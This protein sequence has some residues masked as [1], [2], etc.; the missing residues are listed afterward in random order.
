MIVHQNKL[1]WSSEDLAFDREV[2][3][4][5][6]NTDAED[7][8][9]F[10]S[11][12]EASQASD[13]V[14][15]PYLSELLEKARLQIETSLFR[16]L[17]ILGDEGSGKMSF[18]KMLCKDEKFI[19]V[20]LEETFDSKNLVGTY[21]CNETGEFVFKKGP[22]S[23]AA[24]QGM[25]LVLRNVDKA[26]PDLLSFLLPLVQ[27][28]KLQVTSTLTITPSLG[29]RM[30][31]LTSTS[32]CASI[33]P[34]LSLLHQTRLSPLSSRS[35]FPLILSQKCPQVESI[36]WIK[37]FLLSIPAFIEDQL[38]QFKGQLLD[39]KNSSVKQIFKVFER[40]EGRLP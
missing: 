9:I 40:V 20:T 2:Q 18:V 6:S 36:P 25:W 27:E 10:E 12:A 23:V 8:T 21:V 14:V 35:D 31:A 30:V 16:H 19:V 3:A 17:A 7:V 29:F 1:D 39:H 26:P 33:S 13:S 4:N 5:Y 32:P 37:A 15:T 24:E 34:F 22:L 11:L 28:N 38:R